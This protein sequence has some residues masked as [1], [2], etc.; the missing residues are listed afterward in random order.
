MTG[1]AL[2]WRQLV[3]QNFFTLHDADRLMAVRARHFLVG[4]LQRERGAFLVIKHGGLPFETRVAAGAVWWFLPHGELPT[5]NVFMASRTEFGRGAEIHAAYVLPQVGW[6]VTPFAGDSAMC[7]DE[8]EGRRG[9]I[10]PG[11]LLPGAGRM[12]GFAPCQRAVGT[13]HVHALVKLALVRVDMTDHAG[14]IVKSVFHKSGRVAT[15]YRLVAFKASNCEVSSGERKLRLIVSRQAE[16]GWLKPPDGM[17]VL[18]SV[19]MRRCGELPLVYVRMAGDTK[20]VLYLED[21]INA[22][23]DMALRTGHVSV[24]SFQR[25]VCDHMTRDSEKRRFESFYIVTIGAFA[26]SRPMF[27]LPSMRVRSVAVGAFLV[28]HWRF[29]IASPMTLLASHRLVLIQ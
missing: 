13:S 14:S 15:V 21:R 9:M 25:V 12:A 7:S 22:L 27:E 26:A 24:L 16:V 19:L 17:A 5:V 10:E 8:R 18:A 3:E 2:A 20:G 1:G 11:N 23:G 29:E 4:S 6:V 28:R